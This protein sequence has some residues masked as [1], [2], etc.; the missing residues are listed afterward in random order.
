MAGDQSSS[1][2]SSSPADSSSTPSSGQPA[3]S[4]SHRPISSEMADEKVAEESKPQEP[5]IQDQSAGFHH[6]G[7]FPI[8]T[9]F[10]NS[11]DLRCFLDE[12]RTFFD[13]NPEN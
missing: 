1:Q 12:V 10:S 5:V 4:D 6:S 3:N 7:R 13:E 8:F 11:S 2:T 9:N